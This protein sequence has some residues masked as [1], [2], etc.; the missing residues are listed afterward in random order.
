MTLTAGI[1][2]DLPMA[3]YILDPCPMPSLTA[4]GLNDM[5][6]HSALYF[7][8]RHPRLSPESWRERLEKD[9]SRAAQLG[10]VMHDM[11]LGGDGG[12][13]HKVINPRDYTIKSGPRKGEPCKDF[14]CGEAKA[15]KAEAE[16]EGFIVISPEE[17]AG[18]MEA[19]EIAI[20]NLTR[21]LGEWPAGDSELT[22]VW[23]RG[24]VW[25]RARPDHE[26]LRFMALLN[27]KCTTLEPTDHAVDTMALR[28]GWAFAE[29]WHTEGV[30]T[31]HPEL[32]GRLTYK[33]PLQQIIPPYDFR[34]VDL[35]RSWVGQALQ[36]IDRHVETFAEM[37]RKA[38]TPW[39]PVGYGQHYTAQQPQYDSAAFMAEEALAQDAAEDILR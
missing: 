11:V 19:K 2:P 23:K 14:R 9:E 12:A 1:Y 31:Y 18:L 16:A 39:R 4:S 29:A 21:E 28:D 15:A 30:E 3:A 6:M 7:F 20:N 27:L 10:S 35:R 8:S 17:N 34:M 36:R 33:F 13:K 22:Y 26:A 5:Q 37:V 25:C 24:E 38:G 32:K